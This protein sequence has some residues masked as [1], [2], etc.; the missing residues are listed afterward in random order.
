MSA[1]GVSEE[2]KRQ[3]EGLQRE[4]AEKNVVLSLS[5]KP[6]AASSSTIPSGGLELNPPKLTANPLKANPLKRPNPLKQASA[7]SSAAEKSNGRERKDI[8]L[9]TAEKL[10]LEEQEWEDRIGE[11]GY[12]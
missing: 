4:E 11:L 1:E 6:T 5:A 8:S 3:E 10:I 12:G 2:E 7:S 9:S